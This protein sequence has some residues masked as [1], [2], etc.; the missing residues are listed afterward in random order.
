MHYETCSEARSVSY[1]VGTGILS[2]RQSGRSSK[3]TLPTPSSD[4]V[5]TEWSYTSLPCIYHRVDRTN[6]TF[7]LIIYVPFSS[8]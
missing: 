3:L 6:F 7:H 8:I 1:S 4:E 2:L 5:K